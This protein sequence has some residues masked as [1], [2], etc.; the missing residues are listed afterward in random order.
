MRQ[1][2][3]RHLFGVAIRRALI[4]VAFA[5]IGCATAAA[6]LIL[7]RAP[8]PHDP[9][10]ALA[11]K[12]AAAPGNAETF[13]WTPD[14]VQRAL[15][16]AGLPARVERSDGI[17]FDLPGDLGCPMDYAGQ[18]SGLVT[19]IGVPGAAVQLDAIVFASEAAALGCGA[20]LAERASG[21]IFVGVT[22]STLV[23]S[24]LEFGVSAWTGP[25]EHALE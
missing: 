6:T 11:Q 5:T 21:E 17:L 1:G 20:W 15:A 24:Q 25:V 13:A 8:A 2:A 10:T 14:R 3:A 12:A 19:T 22:G 18:V 9:P 23:L 7:L 4:L 16:D